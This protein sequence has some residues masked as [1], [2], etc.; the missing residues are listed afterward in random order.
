MTNWEACL[1]NPRGRFTREWFADHVA[2]KELLKSGPFYGRVLDV[3]CGVGGRTFAVAQAYP[4]THV[5][6][7]DT[8]PEGIA[9]AR[10]GFSLINTHYEVGDALQ[11]LYDDA[12]FDFAFTL[13]VIE[14]VQDTGAF[15]GR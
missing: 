12:V 4:E 5:Y 3:G 2:T 9:R 11:M 8:S 7:I 15:L 10:L 13:G 14:H 6:G 1:V